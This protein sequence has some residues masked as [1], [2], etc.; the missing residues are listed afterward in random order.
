MNTNMNIQLQSL[1]L[2]CKNNTNITNLYD[3]HTFKVAV[4]YCVLRP[5]TKEH[6]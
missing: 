4:Q 1:P 5:Q 2:K 6:T 3:S